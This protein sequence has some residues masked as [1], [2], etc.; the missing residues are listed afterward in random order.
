MK[1]FFIAL[2]LLCLMLCGVLFNSLYINNV[3]N[4]IETRLD[5]LPDVADPACETAAAALI[6]YWETQVGRVS[7]SVRFPIFDRITE[8]TSLLHAATV[9]GDLYGYRAALALLYDAVDDLR[10][11]ETWKAFF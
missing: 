9:C 2:L 7:L 6:G 5:A 8:Q 3:A 11:L 10:R 4:E 1:S